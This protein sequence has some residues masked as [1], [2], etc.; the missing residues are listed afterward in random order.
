[1]PRDRPSQKK[2]I[3]FSQS[4][5][6]AKPSISVCGRSSLAMGHSFGVSSRADVGEQNKM[7]KKVCLPA[8]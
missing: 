2:C 8:S 6:A 4:P 3:A 7:I 5:A 1:M